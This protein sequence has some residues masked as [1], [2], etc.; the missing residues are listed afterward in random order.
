MKFVLEQGVTYLVKEPKPDSSFSL[1]SSLVKGGARGFCITRVHPK[2]IRKKYEL[3]DTQMLWITTSEIPDERCVHPSDLA[4]LNIAISEALKNPENLVILL[5]GIEYLITYNGFDSILRFVQRINDLVMVTG[6]RFIITLDPATLDTGS[7][8]ILERDLIPIEDPNKLELAAGAPE[9]ATEERVELWRRPLEEKLA[10]WRQ[11]GFSTEALE[12]ALEAGR[13]EALKAFEQFEASVARAEAIERELRAM[14][15]TGLEAE[16]DRVRAKLRNPATVKEAEDE[17]LVL[18]ISLERR[19]K[20]EQRRRAE[21]QRLREAIEARIK[22][23]GEQGYDV[24]PLKALSAAPYE[25]LRAEFERF[26]AAIQRLREL[27]EE[28]LLMDT[29]G[30]EG[31]VEAIKSRLMSPAR[32]SELEDDIFRLKILI[33]RHRKE[34]R[35]RKEEEE[36]ARAELAS[37]IEAWKAEGFDV[38]GLQGWEGWPLERAREAVA[39]FERDVAE[40]K[41][42]EGEL[43]LLP[44]KDADAERA[45]LMPLLRDV[46]KLKEARAELARLRSMVEKSGEELQREEYLRKIEEWRALGYN[47]ERL[48]ELEKGDL[49]ALQKE[50]V[51]F[52]IRVHRLNELKGELGLIDTTGLEAEVAALEPLFRD[53]N[54]IPELEAKLTELRLRARARL[55][56]A[57]IKKEEVARLKSE[58]VEKMSVWASQGFS[59]SRLEELMERERDLEKLRAE[60]DAF[61]TAVV[62]LRE[63]RARLRALDTKGFEKELS[64]VESLLNDP[65][66]VQAAEGAVAALERLIETRRDEARRQAAEEERWKRKAQEKIQAWKS[67]GIRVDMLERALQEGVEPFK[68]ALSDFSLRLERLRGLTEE[69]KTLDTRG[70]ETE[71]EAVKERLGDIENVEGA[72]RALE[73]LKAK[74]AEREERERREREERRLEREA[75]AKK[76]IEWASRGLAVDRLEKIIDGDIALVRAEFERFENGLKRLE[77]LRAA[78]AKMDVRGFEAEAEALGARL[79]RPDLADELARELEE[80]RERVEKKRREEEARLAELR[81]RVDAWAREGLHVERLREAEKKGLAE[82][83]ASVAEFER[84]LAELRRL[85]EMQRELRAKLFREAAAG[86]PV[87][88]PP[89]RPA[90]VVRKRKRARGAGAPAATACVGEGEEVK[91]ARAEE[92]EEE[93]REEAGLEEEERREVREAEREV[94]EEARE[95][96]RIAGLATGTVEEKE[97]AS[98]GA[99][100]EAP[101][102]EGAGRGVAKVEEA[103]VERRS[104]ARRRRR[105]ALLAALVAAIAVSGIYLALF[106]HPVSAAPGAPVIDGKFADWSSVPKHLDPPD[107]QPLNP[108][109]NIVEWAALSKEGSLYVYIRTQGNILSGAKNSTT[110]MYDYDTLRIYLD[111]DLSAATGFLVGGVGAEYMVAIIGWENKAQEMRY[112][113]FTDNLTSPWLP[114]SVSGLTTMRASGRELEVRVRFSDL[115]EESLS[116]N[117]IVIELSDAAGS[118]DRTE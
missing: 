25:E 13:E 43:A 88:A 50:F 5:E 95:I 32:V 10:G 115:G 87:R 78:L 64:E 67:R 14:D 51:V 86:E 75:Y 101:E 73:E 6:C 68:K 35:R 65:A 60:F 116:P 66:K 7:L 11:K 3:G 81:A 93:A 45:R 16:A 24:S 20:E 26:E 117:L 74:I 80:L 109:I 2:R 42:L 55:E 104:A 69:F 15:L 12:R 44:L 77:E 34:E 61:E 105:S 1:F 33:E 54:K 39:A 63:L 37:K 30:F 56:E 70:L 92:G 96:K 22:E 100:R 118:Y 18:Q 99:A 82:L 53:V 48:K 89:P 57:R 9:A 107:D 19:R 111:A 49:A 52:K 85:E 97:E 28:L 76:L 58:L 23:W 112:Y 102:A 114:L 17:F 72:A 98:A 108:G 106:Y 94:E 62:R 41:R 29:T 84:G 31:E 46:S 79:N 38:S 27:R 103:G 47:V 91:A 8:H 40:L 110:K 36:R 21:E 4:K 59:V 71:A 83:E 113:S 90:K